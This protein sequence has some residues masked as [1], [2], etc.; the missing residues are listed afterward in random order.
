M[1]N[2]FY[3]PPLPRTSRSAGR[4]N[5]GV[6]RLVRA[7]CVPG[8]RDRSTR[9]PSGRDSSV[10][11]WIVPLLGLQNFIAVR[12]TTPEGC[13][14]PVLWVTVTEHGLRYAAEAAAAYRPTVAALESTRGEGA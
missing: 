5:R 13:S 9:K 8:H 14:G 12:E 10:L 11:D 4:M 1:A 3:Q 7:L 2:P 6:A